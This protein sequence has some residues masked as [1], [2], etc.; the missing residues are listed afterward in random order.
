MKYSLEKGNVD[1]IN[2]T[3]KIKCMNCENTLA[4]AN[5]DVFL[6]KNPATI[7]DIPNDTIVLKC[8]RCKKFNTHKISELN[9]K[10]T[11]SLLVV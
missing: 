2:V 11:K 7:L 3:N 1:L 6:L 8:T 9:I 10:E 4:L 5:E